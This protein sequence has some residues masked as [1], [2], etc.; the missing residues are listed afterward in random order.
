MVTKASGFSF[1]RKLEC[2]YDTKTNQMTCTMTISTCGV[3][4]FVLTYASVDDFIAETQVI[5]PRMLQKHQTTSGNACNITDQ[6]FAYDEQK[7]LLKYTM[8]GLTYA[9]SS[10][11]DKG[12]PLRGVITGPGPSAS[13]SWSYDD[14]AR[15]ATLIQRA[16]GETRTVYGYD[17]NGNT[18]SV[19]V[20]D[21]ASTSTFTVTATAR[22]CR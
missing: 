21:G 7:R 17:A 4:P 11:D 1:T 6:A 2:A 22:V 19:V 18:T 20:N 5:P 8:N 10:W 12:R 13:E 16:G 3:V 15:T 9:Y 14:A